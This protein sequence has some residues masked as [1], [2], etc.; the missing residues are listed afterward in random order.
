MA[1]ASRLP[2]ATLAALAVVVLA[3]VSATGRTVMLVLL[4][5]WHGTLIAMPMAACVLAGLRGGIRD[6][7]VLAMGHRA[8]RPASS[9]K[10]S[11]RT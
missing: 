10:T 1:G 6:I 3:A 7:A 8:S 5:A 4:V 11:S 2:W 9:S